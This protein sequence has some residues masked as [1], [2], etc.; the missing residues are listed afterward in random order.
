MPG[1][2]EY[3]Y[4]GNYP[5]DRE[6]G[7]S[8]N[9]QG[10]TNDGHNWFFTQE[11]NLWRFPVSHDLNKKVTKANPEK[12]ILMVRMP[13]ELK[14]YNHFGDLDYHED[15]LY[16]PITGEDKTPVI[17]VF[18]AGNL[19]YIGCFVLNGQSGAGWCAINPKDGLL[20]TSNST[21]SPDNP[22][23]RY[24]VDFDKIRLRGQVI[25]SF[26]DRYQVYKPNGAGLELRHMQGGVF[27]EDGNLY[28]VN[29][30]YK[31]CS[32]RRSG[33]HVFDAETGRRIAKSTNGYGRFNYEFHP[34]WPNHE[35]P[36]GITLWD[37]DDGRA[38]KI[39]GRL[40]VIMIDND[41][42]DD[43]LYFKHYSMKPAHFVANRNRSS[44]EVHLK[45]CRWVSKMHEENKVYYNNVQDAFDDG[46]DG[47][48]YC[49]P[50][51]H[52]R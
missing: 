50:E 27:S 36:E 39:S 17:G 28:I 22:M 18:Q 40:H 25:R 4:L 32:R 7:W 12:G 45:D 9:L 48:Y 26:K 19:S 35:E 41:V 16:I 51:R 23:F 33:V 47:C 8:D 5:K 37:L 38:P 49:L 13:S 21:V 29:G 14:G 42:T 30:Y 1:Y 20:Y 10:V 34:G 2:Y 31:D 24:E 11:T 52:H 3:N 6:T 43:D 15:F 44:R 46:Y